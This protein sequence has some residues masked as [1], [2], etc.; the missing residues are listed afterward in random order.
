MDSR[1]AQTLAALETYIK[2]QTALFEQT[3]ADVA[4]LRALKVE[5][6]ADTDSY[7]SQLSASAFR[8][9]ERPAC[10]A[11]APPGIEWAAL[12]NFDPKPLQDLALAARTAH[13]DRRKPPPTQHAP[14]SALQQLVRDARR[15]IVD[16]VLARFAAQPDDDDA[17]KG[18]PEPQEAHK[19][20]AGA[21]AL[22]I[23]RGPSGLFARRAP[24]PAPAPPPKYNDADT[25]ASTGTPDT[26]TNMTTRS[27][28]RSTAATSPSPHDLQPQ[29]LPMALA[30]PPRTRRISTKLRHQ[31]LDRGPAPAPRP[32]RRKAS[33]PVPVPEP[34]PPPPKPEPEP[35]PEPAPAIK[36]A[37]GKRKRKPPAC[38]MDTYKQMW[39]LSEQNLLEQLLVQYPATEERRRVCCARLVSFVAHSL[40]RFAK[41]SQAMNG[42]RSPR[43]VASRV[44]K[45]MQ[46][47]KKWGAD[48]Q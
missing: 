38:T 27:R 33:V 45:F 9:S 3:T 36:S 15:T 22:T 48:T 47:L 5:D 39:S 20:D 35:E 18:S 34:P 32:S 31:N 4:R 42:R 44:Q 43:Q 19:K 12:E 21:G 26:P 23:P 13:A 29:P 7:E 37:L 28:S 46:K 41:I 2:Q 17:D 10:E 16:P 14:P 24:A 25:T 11:G 40:C 8:L 30:K 6:V 1:R